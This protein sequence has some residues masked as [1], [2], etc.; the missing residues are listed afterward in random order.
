MTPLPT[1]SM[2]VFTLSSFYLPSEGKNTV[3]VYSNIRTKLESRKQSNMGSLQRGSMRVERR[4]TH[5]LLFS[6]SARATYAS[7]SKGN[8]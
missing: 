8:D 6:F 4:Q 1:V 5:F 3:S 7:T 2:R